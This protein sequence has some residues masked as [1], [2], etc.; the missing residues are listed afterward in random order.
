MTIHIDSDCKCH[1]SPGEGL[2]TVETDTIY[3]GATK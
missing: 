2:I 1:V 3:T